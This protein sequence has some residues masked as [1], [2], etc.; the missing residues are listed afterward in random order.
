MSR[1]AAEAEDLMAKKLT[2][3]CINN[4]QTQRCNILSDTAS[5]YYP[6]SMYIPFLDCLTNDLRDRFSSHNTTVFRIAALLPAFIDDHSFSEVE[7]LV[8]FYK[9]CVPT[10]VAEL[11]GEYERWSRK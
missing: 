11:R 5:Q 10:T 4:R 6:M 1:I 9:S 2:M 7:P 8:D 3:P